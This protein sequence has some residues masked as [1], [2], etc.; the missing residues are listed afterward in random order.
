MPAAETLNLLLEL[1]DPVD[2]PAL[3]AARLAARISRGMGGR[4]VDVLLSPPN[5]E[6]RPIHDIALREGRLL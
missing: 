4:K 6:P 5:L 2:R 1:P 3:L